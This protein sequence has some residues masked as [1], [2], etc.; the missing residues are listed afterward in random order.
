MIQNFQAK[1]RPGIGM[2]PSIDQRSHDTVS[3]GRHQPEFPPVEEML[4]RQIVSGY[5]FTISR[6]M[7]GFYSQ[8]IR[9]IKYIVELRT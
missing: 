2:S 9:F 7:M 4:K 1:I 6:Q 5:P 8:K 3:R